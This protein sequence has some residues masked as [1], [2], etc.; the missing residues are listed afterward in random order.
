MFHTQA[1]VLAAIL[2]GTFTVVRC[3]TF[4]CFNKSCLIKIIGNQLIYPGISNKHYCIVMIMVVLTHLSDT[5]STSSSAN[6][7]ESAVE[8]FSFYGVETANKPGLS[9]NR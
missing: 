1:Y 2:K 3:F 5:R 4:L 7:S 9:R 8:E 6:R